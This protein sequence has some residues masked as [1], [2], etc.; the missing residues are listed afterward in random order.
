MAAEKDRAS[1]PKLDGSGL[2]VAI[3]ASRWND[4]IVSRLTEG[5]ERGF[6]ALGVTAMTHVSVP[7]AFEIPYAAL[8]VAKSGTVDAIVAVGVVIRGD[9]SHY[10]LITTECASGIQHVQLSTG[11]PVGF[12]VLTVENVEQALARSEAAGGHNV[13]E[14]AAAAAVELALLDLN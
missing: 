5:A 14:E 6:A 7:G 10:E 1:L 9:T 3:V 8:Q 4:A 2:R 12:G 13:G 11:V